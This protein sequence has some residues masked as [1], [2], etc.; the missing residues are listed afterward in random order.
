M[1]TFLFLIFLCAFGFSVLLNLIF[2]F[3]SFAMPVENSA[4]KIPVQVQNVITKAR[5]AIKQVQVAWIENDLGVI[6]S[7]DVKKGIKTPDVVKIQFC[8]ILF[9]LDN[10]NE[11]DENQIVSRIMKDFALG[12]IHLI[13][14]VFWRDNNRLLSWSRNNNQISK[15]AP[16]GCGCKVGYFSARLCDS[17]C[18][19]K[20]EI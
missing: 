2:S 14:S 7:E 13:K 15:E 19:L 8:L 16:C 1:K 17:K 5:G 4:E 10:V 9:A 12:D 11:F 20:K 3:K 6:F 18:P